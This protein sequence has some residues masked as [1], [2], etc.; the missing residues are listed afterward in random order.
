MPVT[1]WYDFLRH[2]AGLDVHDAP[3]PDPLPSSSVEFRRSAEL[4]EQA[5]E[6]SLVRSC[7]FGHRFERFDST[8]EGNFCPVCGAFCRI[9][10][11]RA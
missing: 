8:E 11:V 4:I 5:A 1:D 3:P 10:A 9:L 7:P 6:A 2:A